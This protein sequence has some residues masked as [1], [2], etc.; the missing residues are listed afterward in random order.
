MGRTTRLAAGLIAV[1]TVL[2]G[3]GTA[4][5]RKPG[6]APLSDSDATTYRINAA[7]TGSTADEVTPPV[8]R[9]WRLARPDLETPPLVVDR[10]VLLA[11]WDESS[12]SRLEA[13]ALGTGSLLWGRALR[14]APH[15]IAAG[16]S[17]VFRLDQDGRLSAFRLSDGA[18]LWSRSIA[19]QTAYDFSEAPTFAAGS[20]Y[21]VGGGQ[22]ATMMRLDAR[23]GRRV[24]STPLN[25][26]AATPTVRD[27]VVFVA[28]A[29]PQTYAVRSTDGAVLWQR[30]G[31]PHGGG[32]AL[33][34]A[35][36]D[37]LLVP[38]TV[39]GP[40]GG[41]VDAFTTDGPVSV[42]EGRLVTLERGGVHAA[43][44]ADL[45]NRWL[46]RPPVAAT[47]EHV[48][49]TGDV[50]WTT[51]SADHLRALDLASGAWLQDEVLDDRAFALTAAG[52][53][54]VVADGEGVSVYGE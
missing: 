21:V 6:A 31:F 41:L 36:D 48:V 37:R 22:Q 20:L 2:T 52:N 46:R 54:L 12:T 53:R 47:I 7:Q 27:G 5:E 11:S 17:A 50:V 35:T 15:E 39:L 25:G 8:S 49:V 42:T 32:H 9:R 1:T 13:R 16:P 10:R 29:G 30:G 38:G 24:W 14:G 43:R 40:R 18:R 4:M 19:T 34:T 26:S 23:T 51:D 45:R 3:C 33:A 28:L 44:L